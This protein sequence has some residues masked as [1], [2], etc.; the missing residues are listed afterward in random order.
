[1]FSLRNLAL[2]TKEILHGVAST[3]LSNSDMEVL[4]AC[5]RGE[6]ALEA[7]RKWR[8]DAGETWFPSD[9]LSETNC[10]LMSMQISRMLTPRERE[11]A[12][13]VSEGVP[14]KEVARRLFLSEGTVK[15]HLR[16]IYQ[17]IGL[18]NRT[19]LAALTMSYREQLNLCQLCAAFKVDH[20]CDSPTCPA[21]QWVAARMPS[22]L[23]PNAVIFLSCRPS[24]GAILVDTDALGSVPAVTRARRRQPT[25]CLEPPG[26]AGRFRSLRSRSR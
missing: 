20:F 10:R 2:W 4:A 12:L 14:N 17:K 19:A 6:A 11:V 23:T 22:P 25:I 7:I 21:T 9:L 15:I 18:K 24:F 16:N 13:T 1:M 26:R 8:P 3:L 5:H